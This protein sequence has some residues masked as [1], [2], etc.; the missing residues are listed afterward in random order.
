LSIHSVWDFIHSLQNKVEWW[1]LVWHKHAIILFS[2][3]LWDAICEALSRRD[4]RMSY[5]TIQVNWC[6]LCRGG[7]EDV[8][9]SFFIA[10]SLI[11]FGMIFVLNASFLLSVDL[12]S[13]PFLGFLY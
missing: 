11:A 5:S 6:L 2:F 13:I 7:R 4:K 8:D 9:H 1:E 3:I 12:G 10:C